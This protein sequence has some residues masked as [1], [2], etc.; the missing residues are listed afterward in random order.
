MAEPETF[1]PGHDGS[2]AAIGAWTT[3]VE[4]TK[5]RVAI[6]IADR[7]SEREWVSKELFD[8]LALTVEQ[9]TV[10]EEELRAQNDEL[11]RGRALLN[12]EHARYRE[13]FEHAPV[14]YVV[15]DKHGAVTDANHAAL[16]F[17]HCRFDR[18]RGK[19]LVVFVHEVSRRRFRGL[20]SGL[21]RG[22]PSATAALNVATRDGRVSRVLA[23][24]AAA[25]DVRGAVVE[26]R[27]LLVDQ[28]RQARRDRLRRHDA[29]ELRALVA[30]RTQELQAEQRLKD[31]LVATVSH[32]FR[33][34]LAAVGGYADLLEVGA[35]GPLS[36]AQLDDVH[37][38]KAAYR[39]LSGIV[40][41][42]LTYG[43]VIAGHVALDIQDA[44][45]YDA[46]GGVLELVGVQS[47]ER[48]VSVTVGDFDPRIVVRADVERVRQIVL[49]LLGNAIKFTP[50]GGRVRLEASVR[51][52]QAYLAI[53]DTGPGIPA[54]QA[55]AVFQPFVRLSP[56]TPGTGLGLGISRDL[57][58]AMNGDLYV[59]AAPEAEGPGGG[60][61]VLRLP[62][63]TGLAIVRG[64]QPS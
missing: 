24:V 1:D 8:H 52:Q 47:A 33:T 43:Q 54:E 31:Q 59:D 36:Q 56:A 14:P 41:D 27:W 38:I 7:A 12:S 26:L 46:V 2:A 34:A 17:L 61:L 23:A 15:T 3:E 21:D 10:A 37:R 63:S 62:L 49:N 30:E 29:E 57:A 44:T 11:E 13:L 58:R 60:C 22:K 28:S 20:T 5:R 18:L 50:R 19:P 53:R 4:G 9:L 55:E 48:G 25:F 42:L 45:L 40:D 32:E 39:H 6:L 16:D 64:P 51:D 35:R